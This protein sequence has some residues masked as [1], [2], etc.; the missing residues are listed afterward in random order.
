MGVGREMRRHPVEDDAHPGPVCAVDKA[1]E[2]HRVAEPGGRGI[3]AGGLVAPG[4]II[5]MFADRQELD[6]GEAHVDDIG[7]ELVGELVPGHEAAVPVPPP[8][9]GMHLVDRE[10]LAAGIGRRPVRAVR[11]IPP[12]MVR[13]VRHLRGVGGAHLGGPGE[14]VG[15]ERQDSAIGA[16]DLVFVGGA[17]ADIRDENLPDPRGDAQAH[18]VP[19]SV[20]GVEVTHH[21]HA[22]RIRRPDGEM[23][24]VRPLVMNRMCAHLVEEPQ[25]AA[26]ADIV[27]VHRPEHRAEGIGIG[28]PP[29]AAA[30]PGAVAQGHPLR[31]VDRPLEEAGRMAEFKPSHRRAVE[32]EGLG[33]LG[34]GDEGAR[35]EGPWRPV[36]AE[37]AKGIGVAAADDCLNRTGVGRVGDDSPGLVRVR[38]GHH[39]LPLGM[40]GFSGRSL[41]IIGEYSRCLPNTAGWCDP[42]RTIPCGQY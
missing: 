14:G 6:M 16:K 18:A 3:E 4:R 36:Q 8:R 39:R 42:K 13:P 34:I 22:L 30:V 7:D 2:P 17:D 37:H 5:G 11:V 27:I 25:M 10:R 38:P 19:A 26:F 9:A 35:D 41:E 15:L 28:P 33:P 32:G 1:S 40:P 21:R 23:H 31:Q 29:F 12:D 20:P 24:A